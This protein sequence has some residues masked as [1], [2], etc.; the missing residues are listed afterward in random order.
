MIGHGEY[1]GLG[2]VLGTGIQGRKRE[3]E[4]ERTGRVRETDKGIQRKQERAG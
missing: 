1:P 4:A 2:M 3:K